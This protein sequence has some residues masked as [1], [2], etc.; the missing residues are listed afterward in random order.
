MGYTTTF[1]GRFELD[2]PLTPDQFAYLTRFS[3]TRRMKRIQV[4]L[5]DIPDPM[6]IA[7]GLPLGTE[8]EYFTGADDE[9]G[10]DFDHHSI[11]DDGEPPG[12]QPG[13]WCRWSPTSDRQG[14]KWNG[15]EKFTITTNGYTISF[16][17]F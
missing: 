9:F 7:V 11:M 14:I 16:N 3:Q 12:T 1:R 17:I 10:Q 2:R 13:L 5:N 8:G 6:R 15:W 4:M